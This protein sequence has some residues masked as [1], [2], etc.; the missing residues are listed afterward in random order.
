MVSAVTPKSGLCKKLQSVSGAATPVPTWLK[1][2]SKACTDAF[3]S[4]FAGGRAG[5]WFFSFIAINKP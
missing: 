1:A 4:T 3:T 2:S 5:N